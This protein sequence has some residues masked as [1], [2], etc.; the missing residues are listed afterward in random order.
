MGLA[1]SY[2]PSCLLAVPG[3][4]Q[5]SELLTE[6]ASNAVTDMA[7]WLE[8]KL[9]AQSE[10]ADTETPVFTSAEVLTRR[11]DVKA[12]VNRIGKTP[13]PKPSPT[14]TPE[15][16]EGDAE[17]NAEAADGAAEPA[18]EGV[19]PDTPQ[20]TDAAGEAGATESTGEAETAE[21]ADAAADAEPA[22]DA[23]GEAA[24]PVSDEL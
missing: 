18:E 13:K 15:A 16:T 23:E 9:T 8:G 10:V 20:G 7:E 19:P 14:P 4:A 22:A 2:A 11:R 17:A 5:I 1:A 3:R 24:T 12:T 6:A 21:Q